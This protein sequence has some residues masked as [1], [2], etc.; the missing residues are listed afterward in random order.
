MLAQAVEYVDE[1][2]GRMLMVTSW[3]E[4]HEDTQ[5]EPVSEGEVTRLDGSDTGQAFSE[6]LDY[7]GYGERYLKILRE[8]TE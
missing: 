6:G 1:S 4:W 5:I 7:E 8:G 3:N 2:T